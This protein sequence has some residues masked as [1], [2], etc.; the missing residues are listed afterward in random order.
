MAQEARPA[1]CGFLCCS[2]SQLALPCKAERSCPS[3]TPPVHWGLA[4][5]MWKYRKSNSKSLQLY[6]KNP[7]K[8]GNDP[9]MIWSIVVPSH[10]RQEHHCWLC[11]PAGAI[12]PCWGHRVDHSIGLGQRLH[13]PANQHKGKTQRSSSNDFQLNISHL[14]NVIPAYCS[15]RWT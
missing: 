1:L 4:V 5:A 12:S 8:A 10:L 14:S 13:F 3:A 6:D 11:A 15:L 2:E 7:R 9:G